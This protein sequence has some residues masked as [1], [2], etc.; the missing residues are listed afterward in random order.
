M[1]TLASFELTSMIF[2]PKD[3][4][5]CCRKSFDRREAIKL[6]SPLHKL[7][8]PS[9]KC[10]G[11]GGGQRSRIVLACQL[12]LHDVQD[13]EERFGMPWLGCRNAAGQ[14]MGTYVRSVARPKAK[15]FCIAGKLLFSLLD[16]L[17]SW[18]KDLPT[19]NTAVRM[20]VRASLCTVLF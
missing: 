20:H 3:A 4:W 13:S 10:S 1:S 18:R 12:A 9:F 2:F 16:L 8:S 7:T 17:S 6:Q 15:D 11:R 19:A 5:F 14:W